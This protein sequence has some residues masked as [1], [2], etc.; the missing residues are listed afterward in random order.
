MDKA[1]KVKGLKKQKV[2]KKQR[3]LEKQRK[4]REIACSHG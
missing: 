1:E 3:E 4:Y 2:L